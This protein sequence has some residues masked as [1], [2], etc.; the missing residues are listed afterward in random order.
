VQPPKVAFAL[1]V[2]A[3]ATMP[4]DWIELVAMPERLNVINATLKRAR[5]LL[6]MENAARAFYF[7]KE[8]LLSGIESCD[9]LGPSCAS[10]PCARAG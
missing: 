1:D 5:C 10:Y 7:M 4:N 6:I 9:G 8:F 3:H 2:G